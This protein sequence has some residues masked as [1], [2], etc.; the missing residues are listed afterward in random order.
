MSLLLQWEGSKGKNSA[1]MSKASTMGGL[2]VVPVVNHKKGSGAAKSGAGSGAQKFVPLSV[3]SYED[4]I[5]MA[6]M[7]FAIGEYCC[8]MNKARS[9]G[10]MN[11]RSNY[12]SAFKDIVGAHFW[13]KFHRICFAVLS[14]VEAPSHCLISDF[15]HPCF[16]QTARSV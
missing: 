14:E 7:K 3:R 13:C 9:S 16:A 8:D 1:S 10:A 11:P 5:R 4:S 12:L 15:M 2:G 6:T